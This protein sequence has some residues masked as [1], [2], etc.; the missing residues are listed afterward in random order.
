METPTF[1][2]VHDLPDVVFEHA[3]IITHAHRRLQGKITY[4]NTVYALL[5]ETFTLTQ[6]QAAYE[7]IF[8][9]RLDKRNFRKKFLALELIKPTNTY[10][11][12]G[13]HRPAQLYRF[14]NAKLRTLS[15]S[16]E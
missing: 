15:R 1:F 16:F 2:P 6:L 8:G 7:A 11:T 5:P 14:T 13:A 10:A 9:H 4:T 3:R 12:Q